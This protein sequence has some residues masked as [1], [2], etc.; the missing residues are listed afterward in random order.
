MEQ[1]DLINSVIVGV[2]EGNWFTSHLS[3][4]PVQTGQTRRLN[5]G[6]FHPMEINVA[7]V[8][9]MKGTSTILDVVDLY[10]FYGMIIRKDPNIKTPP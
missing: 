2:V 1:L 9:L 4:T 6:Q 7:F 3:G 5:W 10:M 8:A